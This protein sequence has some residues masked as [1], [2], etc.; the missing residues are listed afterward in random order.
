VA[1][2]WNLCQPSANELDLG[3]PKA[4]WVVCESSP[5]KLK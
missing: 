4:S 3:V 2:R 1:C 5:K